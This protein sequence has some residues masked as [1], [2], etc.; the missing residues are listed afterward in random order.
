MEF[1]I[2]V[3][4]VCG[5]IFGKQAISVSPPLPFKTLECTLSNMTV[6]FIRFVFKLLQQ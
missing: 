6:K 5:P 1:N 2:H 3:P 4:I